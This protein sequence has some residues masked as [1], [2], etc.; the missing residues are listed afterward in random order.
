MIFDWIHRAVSPFVYTL[1]TP[2]PFQLQTEEKPKSKRNSLNYGVELEYVLAFHDLELDLTDHEGH[3]PNHGIEKNVPLA[4]RRDPAWSPAVNVLFGRLANI[5]YNS[6]AIRKNN[7][8]NEDEKEDISNLRPYNLEPQ[9]IVLN[10]LNKKVAWLKGNIKHTGLRKRKDKIKGSYDQWIIST[11][12]TVVGQG[13]ANLYKWIPRISGRSSKRWD[14]YG[15][16]VVSRVLKSDDHRDTAELEEIVKALKGTGD[17]LY[18]GFI[19][20]QCALHVHVEAPDLPIL[21]EL[22]CILLIYEEEISRLH[23]RCR[24]PGHPVA[25]GNLISNRLHTLLGADYITYEETVQEIWDQ[26]ADTSLYKKRRTIQ[27]IR[28]EVGQ[29]RDERELAGYIGFP[30]T[31]TSRLVNFQS[32]RTSSR[33]HTIEFRQARGSL[34]VK[35]VTQWVDF[36]LSLVQL[37]EY[38]VSNPDDRIQEWPDETGDGIDEV[39]IFRLMDAM[40]LSERSVNFWRSKIAK[41]MGSRDED[42]RSDTERLPDK[43]K[44]TPKPPNPPGPPKPPG[45]PPGGPPKPPGGS[46][47]GG[48][49]PPPPGG[50]AGVVTYPTLP[51]LSPVQ[52][53]NP[54]IVPPLFSPKR[55]IKKLPRRKTPKPEKPKIISEARARL[56]KR[57]EE[58]T[59]KNPYFDVAVGGGS[60]I[61]PAESGMESLA[62]YFKTTT[63]DLATPFRIY[64]QQPKPP[65][66]P[67]SQPPPKIHPALEPVPSSLPS[68]P[69]QKPKPPVTFKPTPGNIGAGGKV[70]PTKIPSDG[71][72][73]DNPDYVPDENEKPVSPKPWVET[74]HDSDYDIIHGIGLYR[75]RPPGEPWHIDKGIYVPKQDTPT[76]FKKIPKITEPKIETQVEQ[77]KPPHDT[78]DDHEGV[79][80]GISKPPK[81]AP[82]EVKIPPPQTVPKIP[83]K[84][85]GLSWF[86]G[87]TTSNASNVGP[88][89]TTVPIS[90]HHHVPTTP[91]KPPVTGT[92]TEVIYPQ[93]PEDHTKIQPTPKP[94]PPPL[95]GPVPSSGKRPPTGGVLPGERDPKKP[96]ISPP[97][98]AFKPT[99]SLTV[100]GVLEILESFKYLEDETL[101]REAM[102]QLHNT[103]DANKAIIAAA[104]SIFSDSHQSWLPD[105]A[106]THTEESDAIEAQNNQTIAEDERFALA[107]LKEEENRLAAER[108]ASFIGLELRVHHPKPTKIGLEE[109]ERIN[110]GTIHERLRIKNFARSEW[111]KIYTTAVISGK[112]GTC[113]AAAVVLSLH[114]QYPN[115]RWTRGLTNE[116][117]LRDWVETIPRAEDQ[118]RVNYYDEEQL[119]NALVRMTNG[120]LQL[121][122]THQGLE[123]Y[124]M[125]GPPE[126]ALLTLHGEPAR[127]LYVHLTHMA[128]AKGA[129]GSPYQHFEGMVRKRGY[130]EHK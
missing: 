1:P 61:P 44:I 66:P 130:K 119:N 109:L 55:K 54:L 116:R 126:S 80:T 60:S 73:I 98:S 127:Y 70:H 125:F 20:N 94:K 76:P 11:D 83:P 31:H 128:F 65:K 15:I 43:K 37:A 9:E 12:F 22:V 64:S 89:F 4:I 59:G 3:G 13:S 92:T 6:W 90:S 10:K 113:G 46:P 106:K 21:K 14:S 42:N 30:L 82:T 50:Q 120:E 57:L 74:S 18:E 29:L 25:R 84:V 26:P 28:D 105:Y 124:F 75:D 79:I 81:P 24:R 95:V 67:L 17:E 51:G 53:P 77:E 63:S 35:D 58:R 97:S 122:V 91:L 23:P 68:Q 48:M 33:A 103:G 88:K 7:A 85:G 104:V 45:E 112:F 38:Y 69:S 129:G 16:E 78:N 47:P 49:P 93:L 8:K 36:C 96:K 114:S 71:T 117:F 2:N 108:G 102:E 27:Q 56:I 86:S 101:R 32:L 72:D 100:D 34:N 123:N 107:L 5:I 40:K 39:D 121:A 41:Y 99:G 111:E 62:T 110:I 87:L 115:E 19:T 52:Q 118:G